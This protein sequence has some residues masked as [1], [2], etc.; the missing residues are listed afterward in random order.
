M[1]CK[2]ALK[3][4]SRNLVIG[5]SN[6]QIIFVSPFKNIFFNRVLVKVEQVTERW[7]SYFDEL[8]NGNNIKYWSDLGNPMEA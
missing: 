2:T 7:K 1:Y 4:F 8:F 6:M 5:R 3:A